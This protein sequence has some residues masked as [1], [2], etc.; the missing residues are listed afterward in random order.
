[1]I[2]TDPDLNIEFDIPF[3]EN[4]SKEDIEVKYRDE[5]YRAMMK[6]II[7]LSDNLQHSA[8]PCFA[9]NGSVFQIDVDGVHEHIKN[10]IDYFQANEE[11]ELC[12]KLLTLGKSL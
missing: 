2:Y 8:V 4:V 6:S 1:M 5:V 10:C 9:V 3:F 11:Y 7:W 12:T